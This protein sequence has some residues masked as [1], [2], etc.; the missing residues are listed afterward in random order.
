MMDIIIAKKDM[1]TTKSAAT[2]RVLEEA[3]YFIEHG[4]TVRIISEAMDSNIIRAAGAT[5]IKIFKFPVSGYYRRKF[6]QVMADR[7]IKAHPA[8]LVIGRGDILRQDVLF[9]HN[10]IHLAHERIYGTPLPESN[11]VGRIHTK[12]L[13]EGQFNLLICNSAMMRDD[14]IKRFNIDISKMAIVCPGV[15]LSKFESNGTVRTETRASLGIEADTALIALI[16]SGDFK[17]R[18]VAGMIKAFATISDKSAK[19]LIV[20]KDNLTPYKALAT[21][22][23]IADSVIFA[24]AI[25]D[26]QRYYNACDIFVLPAHIEEFGRSVAEAMYCGLPVIVSRWAGAAD[27]LEGES[28]NYILDELDQL[29]EM[30]DRLACDRASWKHLGELNQTT[31]MKYTK[32]AS[33]A[34]L[35][36]M[37][38]KLD[39]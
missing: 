4:H 31:A 18:N 6:F 28:R 36:K 29:P 7:Y 20:G 9:M 15:D 12:L 26:V 37:Y 5:P 2:N 17:K 8:D 33:M 14:F 16:T 39:I 25:S 19:L 21:E 27:I 32:E 22:L 34:E 10:C 23:G 3:R 30:L 11:D 1:S 13:T 35:E 24:P 38:Q